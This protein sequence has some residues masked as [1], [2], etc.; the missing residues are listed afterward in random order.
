MMATSR[1]SDAPANLHG[2]RRFR[3]TL[4][5]TS[6]PAVLMRL[7]HSANSADEIR[8]S[9][10]G[11]HV[12][13]KLRVCWSIAT[14]APPGGVIAAMVISAYAFEEPLYIHQSTEL[15]L[16]GLCARH[17]PA[18]P[19]RGVAPERCSS[20]RGPDVGTRLRFTE[21]ARTWRYRCKEGALNTRRGDGLR[22][23]RPSDSAVKA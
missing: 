13:S 3:R 16:K 17:A 4:A 5:R 2:T 15:A 8:P 7:T 20:T 11:G 14:A 21:P 12:D 22:S 23:C 1:R 19:L 18:V 10:A 6:S 9:S